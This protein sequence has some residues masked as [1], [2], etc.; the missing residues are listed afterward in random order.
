MSAKVVCDVRKGCFGS[1][2]LFAAPGTVSQSV[3]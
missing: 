1:P 3:L 2:F